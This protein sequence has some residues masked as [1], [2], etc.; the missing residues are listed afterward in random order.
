MEGRELAGRYRLRERVGT[1]GMGSVWRAWDDV[2]SRQVAVK[3]VD[4][5]LL[6]DPVFRERFRDEARA[7]AGLSHPHIVTVHDYG[8]DDGTPYLVME[9]LE[10]ESLA[11]R[12]ARGPL[13]P[14][15]AARICGE[16]ATA[17]AAAHRAG[18]VHGDV[19]PANVFLAA[20]GVRML[21]FGLARAARDRTG[22]RLGTPA[23]LAPEQLG[24]GPA[25]AAADV[26]ALGIVLSEMLTGERPFTAGDTRSAPPP[27]LP[28][29]PA[30]LAGLRERCL[31]ADPARRPSAAEAATALGAPSAPDPPPAPQGAQ[32]SA[33]TL[34]L[35]EPAP[36]PRR[37]PPLRA[38]LTGMSDGGLG[39]LA[40]TLR[41]VPGDLARGVAGLVARGVP[42]GVRG[43]AG[44]VRGGPGGV[45]RGA[46]RG[47]PEPTGPAR[48]MPRRVVAGAVT[49]A[50]V[51]GVVV[52]VV[53]STGGSGGHRPAP[54]VPSGALPGSSPAVTRP[55]RPAESS[56]SVPDAIGALT[57]LRRTVDEGAAAGE[58]RSDVAVD[59]DNLIAALLDRLSAGEPVDVG[60]RVAEL[61]RKVRERLREGGLSA[62][63]ARQ[64]D[65]GLSA[66]SAPG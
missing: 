53:L 24:G 11:G 60:Q 9:L 28:G 3:L 40:R 13:P 10:G 36:V 63:R 22:P 20:G 54:S 57:G 17:L 66:V 49:V 26:F 64:L 31:H 34:V 45:G 5:A 42:G 25:T 7:A 33:P 30:E 18:I 41:D 61:R 52:M 15:E 50:V 23:Y 16:L 21:D 58:V 37:W 12:L 43:V 47:T 65:D 56:R 32:G 38:A 44:G 27:P 8:E 46:P 51:A 29:V 4:P 39:G 2:L 62:G 1:G 14:D 55:S 6:G 35:P 48:G 19:K 59:F